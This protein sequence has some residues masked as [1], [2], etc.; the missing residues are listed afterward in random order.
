MKIVLDLDKLL[1][2]G[3]ITREEYERLQRFASE[4]TSSLGLN[5]LIGFG[6]IAVVLGA[7]TLLPSSSTA[8]VLGIILLSSGIFIQTNRLRNW[9]VLRTIILLVGSIMASGGIINSTQGSV[10]GYL[11]TTVLCL[12]CSLYAKSILLVIISTLSLSASV[13]AMTDYTHAKY[14][15]S[16]QQPTLTILLFSLLSWGSYQLSFRISREYQPLAITFSRTSL[17]LVNFGFW[18]GSL[19][20]DS[21]WRERTSGSYWSYPGGEIIPDWVFVISWAVSLILV[22]IWAAKKNK[23]WVVNLLTVFGAIHFY[24][25]YFEWLGATPMSL[26]FAGLIALGIVTVISNFNRELTS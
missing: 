8:I 19:W 21:L 23:R 15:L 9:R 13:G 10:F 2:E 7:L 6:V 4:E 18:V 26:L 1:S 16:I 25:Q 20:G 14:T 11:L 12:F 17:F 24:T 3:R 22:G 5:I